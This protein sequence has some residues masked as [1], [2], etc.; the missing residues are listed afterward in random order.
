MNERIYFVSEKKDIK[1][2]ILNDLE[3]QLI[4]NKF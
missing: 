3:N 4:K 2:K 1:K